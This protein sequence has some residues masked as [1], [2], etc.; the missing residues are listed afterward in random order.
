MNNL[1]Y[2]SE[3]YEEE[4]KFEIINGKVTGIKPYEIIGGVK[5]IMSPAPSPTH[6]T[7]V[8]RFITIFNNYIDEK[9]INAVVFGDNTDVFFSGDDHFK[10]DISIVCDV[11]IIDWERAVKG[12]PDLIV[13]ILSRSTMKN[14]LG[15]K[16]EE[17]ERYGVKEYWIVDPWSKRIEVYHLID[18]KFKLE[19]VYKVWSEEELEGLTEEELNLIDYEIK[20]SI[21][22]DLTVDIRKIFK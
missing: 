22:E 7:L 21:F 17:Y 13:E 8:G 20:V 18:S 9:N 15:K 4:T 10:P 16:K 5:S 2:H 14:D 3:P 11:N 19:N 6:S 12:T 1:A